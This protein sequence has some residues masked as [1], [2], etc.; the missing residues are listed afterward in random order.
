M[1]VRLIQN[2]SGFDFDAESI[3][4]AFR[5]P[6]QWKADDPTMTTRRAVDTFFPK[7][8]LTMYTGVSY[9]TI[10]RDD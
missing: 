1:L 10:L 4:P 8:G 5:P 9:I 7:M 3:P 2:F 6:P